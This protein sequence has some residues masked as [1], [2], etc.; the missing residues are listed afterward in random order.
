MKIIIRVSL[1]LVALLAVS[2]LLYGSY[3]V[4]V[5]WR[6]FSPR[7]VTAVDDWPYAIKEVLNKLGDKAVQRTEAYK[8]GGFTDQQFFWLIELVDPTRSAEVCSAL[9]VT[10]TKPSSFL[11]AAIHN[12]SKPSWWSPD[13]G[14]ETQ[15]YLSDGFDLSTRGADGEHFLVLVEN[16]T[17]R[18][19]VWQKSNF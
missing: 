12:S 11:T 1:L 6:V 10:Q 16:D 17:G 7:E 14:E 19:F 15:Y 8:V 2:L 5:T 9:E 4:W 3:R 13:L 18:I